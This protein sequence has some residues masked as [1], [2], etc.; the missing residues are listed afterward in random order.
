MFTLILSFLIEI[1]T[2]STES[3]AIVTQ[4]KDFAAVTSA[5]AEGVYV[6]G[7]T[8]DGATF[9]VSLV[10]YAYF[11][12]SLKHLNM[13]SRKYLYHTS[14]GKNRSKAIPSLS[15][16]QKFFSLRYLCCMSR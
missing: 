10:V 14:H 2:L 7:L 3:L 5:P 16:H 15:L 8:M 6:H 4:M 1:L 12:Q 9:D 11:V 13:S